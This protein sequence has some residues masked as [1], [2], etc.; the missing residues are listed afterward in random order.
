MGALLFVVVAAVALLVVYEL[1]SCAIELCQG[2]ARVRRGQ[3]FKGID[4]V[5]EVKKWQQ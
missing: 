2:I 3:P 5:K 1:C 4:W